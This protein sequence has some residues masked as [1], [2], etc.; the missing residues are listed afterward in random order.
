MIVDLEREYLAGYQAPN[1]A[2]QVVTEPEPE[3]VVPEPEMPETSEQSIADPSDPPED[4]G[5]TGVK[6]SIFTLSLYLAALLIPLFLLRTL[7]LRFLRQRLK[8]N[9]RKK[10]R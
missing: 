2:Y 1:V 8:S 6:R 9:K 10:R 3:P 5:N 7:V 4:A